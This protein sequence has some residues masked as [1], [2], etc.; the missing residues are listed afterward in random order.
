M[1]EAYFNNNSENLFCCKK[2]LKCKDFY[3]TGYFKENDSSFKNLKFPKDY[4]II[5]IGLYGKT[6]FKINKKNYSLRKNQALVIPSSDNFNIVQSDQE[7]NHPFFLTINETHIIN[8][9]IINNKNNKTPLLQQINASINTNEVCRDFYRKAKKTHNMA[10]NC[11]KNICHDFIKKL[12]LDNY[13]VTEQLS[14]NKK[15]K[16]TPLFI[17]AIFK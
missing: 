9:G 10:N 16:P 8:F 1:G 15:S 4:Y 2:Y 5:F 7:Q 14:Q 13:N 3:M 12:S 6:T 17:D 11:D